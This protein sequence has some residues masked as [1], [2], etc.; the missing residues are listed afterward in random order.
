[1]SLIAQLGLLAAALSSASA[2]PP[3]PAP[4]WLML[5]Y[6]DADNNLET[7]LME[8]LVE[9]TRARESEDVVVIALVDRGMYPQPE[10]LFPEGKVGGLDDF[11]NSK[12]VR[13][14]HGRLEE[15]EDWGELD[16]GNPLTLERL[17]KKGLEMYK[18]DRL[19]LIMSDHGAGWQGGWSD[20]DPT[21]KPVDDFEDFVYSD[22]SLEE[23]RFGLA[24]G[25]EGRKL[26]ILGFDACLMANLETAVALAPYAKW[27]VASEE[28]EPGYGWHFEPIFNHLTDNPDT[29][30]L[31]LGK[32]IC[33]SFL[34]FYAD[35]PFVDVQEMG[36]E[37]TLSVTNLAEAE[38]LY[39]EVDELGQM[40][41]DYITARPDTWVK[42]ADAQAAMQQFGFMGDETDFAL[43]D[44]ESICERLGDVENMTLNFRAKLSQIKAI[45]KEVVPHSVK[46]EYIESAGGL[47][48]FWPWADFY[49]SG[50]YEDVPKYSQAFF[51]RNTTPWKDF[52]ES[53]VRSLKSDEEPPELTPIE[54]FMED[55]VVMLRTRITGE[56]IA[57][58][59]Y[60]LFRE[61]SEDSMLLL[62][63]FPFKVPQDGVVT[64]PFFGGWYC[65]VSGDD[66]AFVPIYDAE[67]GETT[68]KMYVSMLMREK[69]DE[70]WKP[71]LVAFRSG[72]GPSDFGQFIYAIDATE[73]QTRYLIVPEGAEFRMLYPRLTEEATVLVEAEDGPTFTYSKDKQFEIGYTALPPG[74]YQVGF[75]VEDFS[76]NV[77]QTLIGATRPAPP[78]GPPSRR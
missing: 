45:L 19:G 16:M 43:F 23:I 33:D 30:E 17:L 20:D 31:D 7:P 3:Q 5:A 10:E 75:V 54:Q 25:L 71:V 35:S 76:G 48:V 12:L 6:M 22:L 64:A 61:E 13:V 51:D 66:V 58:V 72:Y 39:R 4:K 50:E 9:M 78:A 26:D 28:L 55:D 15:L 46:G 56:D 40:L 47:T 69:P 24:R 67:F 53:Y 77:Q 14:R 34:K 63:S 44:I 21:G 74:D 60:S 18:P 57:S 27:M 29:T 2:P 42:I 73:T 62:G 70:E 8:D 49:L 52:V 59:R 68:V 36:K 41:G 38:R 1:M 32:V 11:E 37:S 65:L